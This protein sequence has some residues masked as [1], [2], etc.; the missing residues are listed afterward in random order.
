[1]IISIK[2]TDKRIVTGR[3]LDAPNT[4]GFYHAYE[5]SLNSTDTTRYAYGQTPKQLLMSCLSWYRI[6]K[7]KDRLMPLIKDFYDEN[8]HPQEPDRI[9]AAIKKKLHEKSNE[10]RTIVAMINAIGCTAHAIDDHAMCYSGVKWPTSMHPSIDDVAE[11]YYGGSFVATVQVHDEKQ[12]LRST[13]TLKQ[14]LLLAQQF[15]EKRL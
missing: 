6:N 14:S 8:S 13:S 4:V 11:W 2:K 5:T 15:L 9:K 10:V 3:P 12:E 7:N 1:M